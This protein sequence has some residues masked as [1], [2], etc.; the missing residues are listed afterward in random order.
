MWDEVAEKKEHPRGHGQTGR[1]VQSRVKRK[2]KEATT[3][4]G[5]N[6]RERQ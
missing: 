4:G 2:V 5:E 6:F 3:S 1:K